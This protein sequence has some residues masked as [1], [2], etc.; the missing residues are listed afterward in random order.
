[1]TLEERIRQRAYELW[2][3]NGRPEG[4]EFEH[5]SQARQEIEPFYKEGDATAGSVESSV[6]I[7]MPR[8]ES[9]E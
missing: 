1:M 3:A 9:S 2:E 6:A 5:W 7:P 8:S 4:Q